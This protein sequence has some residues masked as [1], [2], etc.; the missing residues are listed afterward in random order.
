MLKDGL[1]KDN[2]DGE[3]VIASVLNPDTATVEGEE[4]SDF[5]Y[6]FSSD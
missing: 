5:Q 6:Q 1:K 2:S 4:D 3:S